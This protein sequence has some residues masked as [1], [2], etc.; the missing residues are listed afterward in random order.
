MD[1]RA[2]GRFQELDLREKGRKGKGIPV[3]VGEG[4]AETSEQLSSGASGR[5]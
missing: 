4:L 5:P 2:G 3:F 1:G